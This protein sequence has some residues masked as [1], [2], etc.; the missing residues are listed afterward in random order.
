MQ[1]FHFSWNQ[2]YSTELT[3]FRENGD[4]GEVWF[5]MAS[6]RRIVSWCK[7]QIN[8][9]S[10]AI[11]DLGCG[12]GMVLIELVS[13]AERT[14]TVPSNKSAF[15]M[16]HFVL[17]GNWKSLI[18]ACEFI[19]S[20]IWLNMQLFLSNLLDVFV[21]LGCVFLSC[22]SVIVKSVSVLK[23]M[24][25]CCI[26]GLISWKILFKTCCLKCL[27]RYDNTMVGGP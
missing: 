1:Y 23:D 10:A 14:G 7:R 9:P 13:S 15:C 18:K 5:S 25:S 4:S 2:F 11:L 3:N 8:D 17:C 26:L 6:V 16:A 24:I 20:H 27:I 19:P 12:N 21:C 22:C